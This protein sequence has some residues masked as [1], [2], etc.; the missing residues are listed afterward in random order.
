MIVG[1]NIDIFTPKEAKVYPFSMIVEIEGYFKSNIE[2]KEQ[3]IRQYEKMR[4]QF[5]FPI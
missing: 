3:D 4:L 2:N 5:C 1:L